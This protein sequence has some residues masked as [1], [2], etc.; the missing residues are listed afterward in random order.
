MRAGKMVFQYSQSLL[1][2]SSSFS[3]GWL[4][5]SVTVLRDNTGFLL[6]DAR[7]PPL[8]L[9]KAVS[10]SVCVQGRFV[11]SASRSARFSRVTFQMIWLSLWK[12]HQS[13]RIP[14][15]ISKDPVFCFLLKRL[16]D[17]HRF[18]TDPFG[19]LAEFI[20]LL[21]KAKKKTIRELSRKTPDNIGA[22]F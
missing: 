10:F 2:D 4:C 12:E 14:S 3:K 17:D 15:W 7:C 9:A 1:P 6:R 20:V 8:H 5:S 21:E 18:P 13:K 16:H 19:A 22:S 11:I